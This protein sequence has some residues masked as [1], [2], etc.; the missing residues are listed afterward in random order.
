[1]EQ[2]QRKLDFSGKTAIVT[3]AANG[4][5][6]S[7]ATSLL[8]LGA[9]VAALGLEAGE[10]Q[11]FLSETT[12]PPKALFWET[13]LLHAPDIEQNLS[14]VVKQW[15]KI[16]ILVCPSGTI[17]TDPFMETRAEDFDKIFDVNV[18][19][20]FL[21]NQAALSFMIER[22]YGKIVNISSVAGKMGGGVLGSTL[23]GSS[24]GAVIAMSKGIAHETAA[25]SLNVNCVCA[26]PMDTDIT[27]KITLENREK[28]LNASLF[29][30]FAD[31]QDITN[32]VLF[33][34]SDHA[35]HITSEII[36]VDG[37]I[38]KGN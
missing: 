17:H 1:M 35:K 26:G 22:R 9:N 10:W 7:I 30:R 25:Y 4:V 28:I 18:K 24:M 19:E 21:C 20:I 12:C 14:S 5:G 37:G 3:N 16:D 2:L 29:K 31:V 33:L 11:N 8:K 13:N 15:G 27:Q 32:T 36:T 6:F 34:V 38:T 23:Y